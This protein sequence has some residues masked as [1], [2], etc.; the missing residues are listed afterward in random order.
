MKMDKIKFYLK[1]LNT[2]ELLKLR[3][4]IEDIVMKRA[5]QKGST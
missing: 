4:L 1:F 3:K 2:E 5:Q